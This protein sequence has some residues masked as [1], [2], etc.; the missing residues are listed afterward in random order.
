VGDRLH[1]Y[2]SGRDTPHSKENASTRRSTG[3]A[4]L[5]RDGFYSMDAGA[6]AGILTTRPVRFSGSHLF[7]NVADPSGQLQVEVLDA[8]G[9][10]IP[11]F[12]R[13]A[14]SVVTA[15]TTKQEVTWSG[16][17]L[18]ALAGRPVQFRFY[19]SNGELYSFW[20][21]SSASGASNGYVA[22]GGPGFTS[23]VD[24]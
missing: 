14:S 1:I 21:T 6:G 12:S 9:N 8:I 7:V 20:V 5:R 18:G 17:S 3:L 4:F 15:D 24:K 10:V 11:Q 13:S 2:F 16:A 22:A 19:L 23:D